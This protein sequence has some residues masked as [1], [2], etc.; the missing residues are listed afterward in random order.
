MTDYYDKLITNSTIRLQDSNGLNYIGTGII[1]YAE[2][3]KDK[4]Y[5]LTASHC[6]FTD[7]D[8]FKNQ[9]KNINLNL[10]NPISMDYENIN[11]EISSDYLFTEIDKDIAVLMIDKSIIENIIKEIPIIKVINQRDLHSNFITKGFPKA[12]SGEELAILYPTWLHSIDD[13]RFQIQLN[14]DYSEYNTQ[15]FSGSGVFLIA[16]DEVYLFGIFTR[17]RPQDKGKVIYCQ[18]IETINELLSLV[19]T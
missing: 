2:Y 9:R 14:E 17:F 5:I 1:Y 13:K 16:N 4:V 18:Y 3:L 7:N 11:Y 19:S 8:G 10:Y 6:L 12:T 15:G